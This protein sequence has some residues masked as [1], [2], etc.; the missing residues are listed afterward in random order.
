MSICFLT[1]AELREKC[2]YRQNR[3]PAVKAGRRLLFG[4]ARRRSFLADEA[5]QPSGR[6]RR[7][8][9]AWPYERL[10]AAGP[11]L[12]VRAEICALLH[13]VPPAAATDAAGGSQSCA[14]ARCSLR[15][16]ALH[17]VVLRAS[18]AKNIRLRADIIPFSRIRP[19]R[20]WKRDTKVRLYPAHSA[21]R[22]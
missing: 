19:R 4:A 6:A 14:T 3:L 2:C 9:G 22:L 5:Q 13:T 16:G 10:C 7:G 12:S 1:T 11:G 8:Q 15:H 21:G 17:P 18:P 20:I